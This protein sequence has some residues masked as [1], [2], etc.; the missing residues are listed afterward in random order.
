MSPNRIEMFILAGLLHDVGKTMIPEEILNAPRRLTE[1]EMEIMRMHPVYSD[2]LLKDK[3]DD[4]I[5]SAARHHHEKLNGAGYPDGITGDAIGLCERVTAISDIYDA[6]VS[7]RSY[8]G[9]RMPLHILH[10]LYEEEF[11]GLDRGLVINFIKNMRLKYVGK[12]VVMTDGRRGIIQ[13]IPFNDAE[14]PVIRQGTKIGQTN[15]EWFCKAMLV[16]L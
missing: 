14:H 6:M 4:E 5:R 12:Q 2:R 13:Y 15:E 10:M 7:A 8:K 11:K 9:S 1:D 3:F 16:D